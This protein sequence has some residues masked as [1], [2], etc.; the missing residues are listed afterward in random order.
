MSKISFYTSVLHTCWKCR[1]PAGIVVMGSGNAV[2]AYACSEAHAK[3]KVKSLST[4]WH[5]QDDATQAAQ[6]AD[7]RSTR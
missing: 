1:K 4:F 2:Y 6:V 7:T 5:S 3:Q